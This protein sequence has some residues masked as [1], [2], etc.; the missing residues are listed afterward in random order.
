[1]L[2]ERAIYFLERVGQNIR[3]DAFINL[4]T[5]STIAITLLIL[6]TFWLCFL[7]LNT[8]LQNWGEKIQ[9]TA[10]LNER[11]SPEQLEELKGKIREIPGIKEMSFISKDQA[12][13][14]FREQLGG[15][16]GLLEG[17]NSNPLPASWEIQ[18]QQDYQN[19]EK[20][21]E[22]VGKL[23]GFKEIE[24]LQ[25]GQR[26]VER[27]S[28]FLNLLRLATFFIGGLLILAT[29]FII[30][31]TIKLS[32]Y[33]RKEEIEIMKLV[34]AADWFIKIPFFLGGI[35]QGLIGASIAMVILYSIY[36]F[37]IDAISPV[38]SLSLGAGG[39]TF[40]P[41]NHI[42]WFLLGGMLLGLAGSFT[43]LGR[44]LR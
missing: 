7:N 3:Q 14:L 8:F 9:I 40:L 5:I 33:A 11:T 21:A 27:F 24:D 12:L 44:H 23:K 2:F 32:V 41:W 16:D 31:N 22:I 34:G 35:L 26:W 25:Y 13:K 17:L 15:Q 19:S 20:A 28:I 43:S 10:Y 30:S 42:Y 29:I 18:L 38:M 37:L 39:L 4:V 36:K 1:M 6:S